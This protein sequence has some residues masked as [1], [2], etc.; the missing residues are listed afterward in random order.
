MSEDETSIEGIPPSPV[1]GANY[2]PERLDLPSPSP[3]ILARHEDRSPSLGS[4]PEEGGH[5]ELLSELPKAL[6]TPKSVPD[7]EG[8]GSSLIVNG[9]DGRETSVEVEEVGAESPPP[10]P[11][12]PIDS[13]AEEHTDEQG[14][15]QMPA[16]PLPIEE[17]APFV[18][19]NS[20][21]IDDES[22]REIVTPVEGPN[23]TIQP[24][25]PGSSLNSKRADPFIKSIAV[26]TAKA[27]AIEEENGRTTLK[28]R[29]APSPTTDRPRTPN[30]MRSE[31][32]SKNFLKVFLN[33]VFVEWIGGLI[34][35]L[36]GG[37]RTT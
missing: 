7:F 2:H 11:V 20:V 27:T 26:D 37:G 22:T 10:G 13:K 6:I 14:V 29:K 17:P 24:A 25:T 19:E 8:V 21:K 3:N 4:I 23:I 16:I 5:R 31:P 34:M 28:S 30:S 15:T 9:T 35:R 12:E 36:C 32:N 1:V 18:E 33:L